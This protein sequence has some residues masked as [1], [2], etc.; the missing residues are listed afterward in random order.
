MHGPELIASLILLHVFVNGVY[1]RTGTRRTSGKRHRQK[2]RRMCVPV[3]AALR[4]HD[5]ATVGV[6]NRV[7]S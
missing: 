3:M 5:R 2:T 4:T 7:S 6:P 1:G